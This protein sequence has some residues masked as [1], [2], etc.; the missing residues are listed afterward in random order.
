MESAPPPSPAADGPSRAPLPRLLR[1]EL[2]WIF[3]RPRTLVVLGLLAAIPVI[4]GVAL[5]LVD[6]PGPPDGGGDGDG[7]SL[8]ATAAGNALVLPIAAL[9]MAL[10][11]LLPLTAAMVGGD[12][13]AGEQAHG[14]LRGWLLAPVS[15]GRLLFV[16][17]FG[18]ATFA[19]CAAG[20]MAL[21]GIVTGLVINGTDALVSLSGTTLTFPEALLKVAIAAG[22]VSLQLWAVGAVALAIS[23]CTEH[24]MVVL[25][26]VLGGVVVFSVLQFLDALD[27]LHPFLLN[28]SWQDLA[29]VLR[30]PMPGGALAE[31]ALRAACY[32]A[33]A[34][35]L[36]Y[37]RLS[38]KDG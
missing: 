17:A 30:D 24:P 35:S 8:V 11:L 23:A 13:L 15:R 36:A 1:A 22:W 34:L 5:T 14:T 21:T 20:V 29:D 2:R 12:A 38:T 37:A 9:A 19:V 26:S 33:I 25:A 3:R 28:A 31:G 7:G 32:I 10:G 4:I 18:V 27:W 6:S 16:K